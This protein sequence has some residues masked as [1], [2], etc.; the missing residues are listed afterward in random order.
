M[1][2]LARNPA[3]VASASAVG[4][5]ALREG[6]ALARRA[7]V[8]QAVRRPAQAPVVVVV[9]VLWFV[10]EHRGPAQPPATAVVRVRAD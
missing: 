9:N 10:H 2:R 8:R 1:K 5:V 7:A 3:V 4:A 6:V